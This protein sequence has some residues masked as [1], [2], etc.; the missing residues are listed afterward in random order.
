MKIRGNSASGVLSYFTRHRTAANLLLV[1]LIVLGLAAGSRIRSQFFP[2]VI[3]ESISVD[4]AWQGAGPEDVDNGI[5]AV[6]EP[7][8]LVVE[9]VTGSNSTAREGPQISTW[10]SNPVGT[11]PVPTRM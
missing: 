2:D 6:L 5:V 4:V 10:N 9:G 1:I 8:L 11:C 7:A 3:I